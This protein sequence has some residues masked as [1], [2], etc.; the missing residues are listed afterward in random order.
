MPITADRSRVFIIAAPAPIRAVASPERPATM[1][2]GRSW[3]T[4]GRCSQAVDRLWTD[5][6]EAVDRPVEIPRQCR[7]KRWPAPGE[8][9]GITWRRKLCLSLKFGFRWCA[10]LARQRAAG[11]EP[12]ARLSSPSQPRHKPSGDATAPSRPRQTRRSG[13]SIATPNPSQSPC[14]SAC[15]L[16][17][18]PF[19]GQSI[20]P[21]TR[22]T[23][24]S[25]K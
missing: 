23:A 6:G 20:E 1:R 15:T 16:D 8:K 7:W 25:P 12:A 21:E 4:T 17:Q 19:E 3:G 9:R 10:S 5:S 13:K 24:A 22:P 11:P 14:R 2:R 18:P